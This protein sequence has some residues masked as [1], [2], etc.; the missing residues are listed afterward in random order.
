M[1]KILTI[2]I[3]FLAVQF[4]FGQNGCNDS[5]PNWGENEKLIKERERF[6]FWVDSLIECCRDSFITWHGY[7]ENGYSIGSKVVEYDTLTIKWDDGNY[8]VL[9]NVV[10]WVW[11][12]S[13]SYLPEYAVWTTIIRYWKNSNVIALKIFY[14]GTRNP[15]AKI[16]FYLH[17]GN[18]HEGKVICYDVVGEIDV[19]SIAKELNLTF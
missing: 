10:E 12:I 14:G 8:I 9:K 18:Y 7:G 2:L 16:T 15:K 13:F 11:Q 1:K 4:A 19:E 6:V 17:R 5:V 3:L